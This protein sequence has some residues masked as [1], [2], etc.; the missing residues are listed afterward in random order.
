MMKRHAISLQLA[1][2]AAAAG[3]L[4]GG[5]GDQRTANKSSLEHALNRDYSVNADCLFAKALPFPFEVSVSD[6]HLG[7]TRS[8][9]DALVET[10]LLAR[11]ESIRGNQIVN[12]YPS[13]R[14]ARGWKATAASAMAGVRSPALR[15][16]PRRWI[17]KACR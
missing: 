17:I 14:P 8:R 13:R 15:T 9:L 2:L 16:S 10:G 3:I 7:Q 5:C 6:K 4:A 1:A 12:R 11:E